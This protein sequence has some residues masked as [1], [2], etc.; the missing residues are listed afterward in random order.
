MV[1]NARL[2]FMSALALAIVGL[3]ATLLISPT[4][5]FGLETDVEEENVGDN[6]N[7]TAPTAVPSQ[8][9]LPS[10]V[11]PPQPPPAPP[12]AP[13]DLPSGETDANVNELPSTGSGGLLSET[14]A[15]LTAVLLFGAFAVLGSG[16]LV[17]AFSRVRR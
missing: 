9:S 14:E 6:E 5:T 3:T 1:S 16:T 10:V 15:N 4:Q 8:P 12:Q 13:I 2:A 7:A 11:T 17:W